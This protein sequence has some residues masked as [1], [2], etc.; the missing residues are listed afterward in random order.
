MAY[1]FTNHPTVLYDPTGGNSPQVVIDITR[2]FK[3]GE[4]LKNKRLV[5]YDYQIK[6]HDRPDLMAQKYY[7][8]PRLDWLFFITND[9]YDPYF[10]WPLNYNQ[11]TNYIRQK[12]GSVS[13]AQGT[14]HHYEQ[15]ITQR[16]EYVSN[17]DNSVIVIPE[18]TLIVD[19]TTYSGLASTSK[20]AVS[21]FDYEEAANN[22]KRNIKILD[23]SYV[24]SLM[25]EFKVIFDDV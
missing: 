12:Y 7:D 3:I 9:I 4:L 16:Q 8:D 25:Q 5:L 22:L 20:R 21:C 17:Y 10:Q 24:P 13:V 2:R 11:L 19:Y 23:K 6:E 18:K 14:N 1:F 15:I